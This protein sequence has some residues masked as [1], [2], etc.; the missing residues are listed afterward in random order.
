[1]TSIIQRAYECE[2]I[3]QQ[4]VCRDIDRD[5]AHNMLV[6]AGMLDVQ[7]AEIL[8][9]LEDSMARSQKVKP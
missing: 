3:T 5:T 2:V 6:E 7:A 1:M 4:F 8:D 9:V